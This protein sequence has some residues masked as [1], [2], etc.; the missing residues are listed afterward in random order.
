MEVY[1][2]MTIC[3]RRNMQNFVDF[4]SDNNVK[5]GNISFGVGT[6]SSDEYQLG[7]KIVITIHDVNDLTKL[8]YALTAGWNLLALP[9]DSGKILHSD[10][11]DLLALKPYIYNTTGRRLV[12]L[13]EALQPGAAFW[14]YS[15]S[16]TTFTLHVASGDST[17]APAFDDANRHLCAPHATLDSD[18]AMLWQESQLRFSKGSPASNT[19][20]GWF[21][22]REQIEE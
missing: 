3:N 19:Q 18:N 17:N 16:A 7:K 8:E 10:F 11:A 14:L 20:G 12:R 13:Q 1:A 9:W 6:A 21:K 2:M 15:T 5:T 4:Y 22:L